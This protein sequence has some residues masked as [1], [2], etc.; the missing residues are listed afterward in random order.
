[1]FTLRFDMRAPEMGAPPAALY[2]AAP[3][4]CAWAE[5]RGCVATVLCEHHG[6]DDGYLPSPLILGSAIASRTQ[7][8]M[9]SL[10]VILPFYD[11]VR[12][13]EDITVLDVI[14]GGRAAYVFGLGY[15]AEE[16]AHFGVGVRD[17]GRLADEKMSVLRRLLSG[18][19]V[20]SATVTP[21]PLTPGGPMMMWGGSS[22]A[23]A[24][25]AGRYGLG[26]LANGHVAGMREVYEAASRE[27]GFEPGCAVLPDKE[28]P[29][30]CFVADDVDEAWDEIGQHLLHDARMY[31]KWNP[32][33]D[34]SAGISEADSVEE[35]RKTSASHR[36]LTVAEAVDIIGAGGMLNLAPLC[37][38]L[39]P[40]IAWGYLKRVGEAVMPAA[41]G[42]Q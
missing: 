28:T 22:L 35:L 24:R 3:Q 23:A 16:F 20:G 12:L 32:G 26:L 15:R 19:T 38:G 9:L 34:V 31:A 4:M 5:D 14:S 37:G 36:I 10:V 17:R 6:S 30:V 29:T 7:R 25:R 27:H 18:E 11:P 40:E 39:P 13:A 2:A 41:A 33:N 42:L 21:R 1:V 8:M